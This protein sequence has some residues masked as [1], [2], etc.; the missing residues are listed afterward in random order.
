LL[1]GGFVGVERTRKPQWDVDFAR[2][3]RG[4]QYGGMVG[5]C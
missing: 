3:R 2:Y 4:H 5:F 1:A